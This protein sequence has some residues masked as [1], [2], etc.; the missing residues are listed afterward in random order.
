MLAAYLMRPSAQSATR[1]A[2][3]QRGWTS[4]GAVAVG[5]HIRRSDKVPW[6][7]DW[8]GGAT[9]CTGG[10]PLNHCILSF[11]VMLVGP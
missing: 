7:W 10:G 2:A 8:A 1:H 4:P 11:S 5:V 9:N 6:V 3:V